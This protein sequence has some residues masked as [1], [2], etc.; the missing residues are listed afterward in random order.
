GGC[1]GN[2]AVGLVGVGGGRAGRRAL[3]PGGGD[4]G[5]RLDVPGLVLLAVGLGLATYGASKG[6]VLGW[7]SPGSAPAWAGGLVL[8]A[9]YVLRERRAGRERTVGRERGAPAAV[10]LSLL[11]SPAPA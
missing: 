6:P 2:G 9:C 11:S 7:L 3:A 10:N 5:A 8:V 4:R 1:V